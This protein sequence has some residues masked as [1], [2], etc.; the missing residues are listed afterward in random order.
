MNTFAKILASAFQQLKKNDE[1]SGKRI[2]LKA[3][4]KFDGSFSKFR[5]WWESIN[6]SFVIH[7]KTVPNDQTKTYS[8]STFQRDQAAEWYTERTRSMKALHL[9]DNGVAFSAAMEE[10]FND[11][12]EI[13]KDHEKLLALEYA[14][15][16]QTYLARFNE[17]NSR[18]QLSEQSLKQVLTAAVTPDMYRNIWRK[19]SKIPDTD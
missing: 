14:G 18:V 15:D 12:Q 17:L 13:G 5:R 16:M 2:P 4:K 9:D 11:R 6:E 1:D 19:N 7:Q 3:P 10:R 8:L